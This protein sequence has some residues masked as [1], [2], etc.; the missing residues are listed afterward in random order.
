MYSMSV[1]DD[2]DWVNGGY[3]QDSDGNVYFMVKSGCRATIDCSMFSRASEIVKRYGQHF[4]VIFQVENVRD[5]D[6]TWLRCIGQTGESEIGLKMNAQEAYLYSGVATSG[7]NANPSRL[8]S[9]YSENDR[10]EYEY[11]IQPLD[12]TDNTATSYIMSYEDGTMY[13]PIIYDSSNILQQLPALHNEQAAS[14][15]K[16]PQASVSML[17]AVSSHPRMILIPD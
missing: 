8:R 7:S 16:L 4:K 15:P 1:S 2:F 6:A 11:D 14:F 13:R 10:I 9:E 5:V 3:K 17:S 12:I